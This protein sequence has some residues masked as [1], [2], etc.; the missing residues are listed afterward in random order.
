MSKVDSRIENKRRVAYWQRH[1]C[2][3][4]GPVLYKLLDGTKTM[5]KTKALVEDYEY[6]A[7]TCS[8]CKRVPK[9]GA[10]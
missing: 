9:F 10:E 1:D 7:K 4:N 5:S 8:I 6:G 3:F 2:D